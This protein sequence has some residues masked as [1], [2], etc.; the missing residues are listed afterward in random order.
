MTIGV[1]WSTL[2]SSRWHSFPVPPDP[3]AYRADVQRAH[4]EG[5]QFV[6][7]TNF[8]MQSDTGDAWAYWG[9]EWNG[10]A[11]QGKAADVLAMNLV[12]VRCCAMTPSW[13]DFITWKYK[14]FLDEYDSDGFYL[15]NSVPVPC[16]NPRH[17]ASHHHRRHI[18]AARALMKRIYTINKRNDPANLM[19]CHMSTCLC[20]PVLS[21]CDAIVDGEQYGWALHEDFDGHYMPLTP[22]ARVRAELMAWQWGPVPFF[23][24][25]NRG[26]NPWTPKLM[27]ELLALMLPHGMRFWHSG[28]RQTMAKVLDVVDAFGLDEARFI[29]YWSVADWRRMADDDGLV[30]SAYA[31]GERAM[32][33]V[34]NLR[35]QPRDVGLTLDARTLGLAALPRGAADPL[36]GLP[37]AWADGKLQLRI[38][39]RDLRIVLLGQDGTP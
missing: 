23:L 27:R 21:F 3:A 16:R 19:V 5:K 15:D 22:L 12:N 38:E 32:L 25:C 35:A 6:P 13:C 7:Y 17:P 31:R 4:A 18:F 34:A 24:P 1:R 8:N 26:P 39:G 29:P 36:D 28:H 33:L 37:A 20:I 14:T 2:Q 30:L 10:Y 11:G 9:E